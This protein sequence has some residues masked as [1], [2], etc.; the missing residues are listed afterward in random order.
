VDSF[1]P[2]VVSLRRWRR[3]IRKWLVSIDKPEN[4]K[5]H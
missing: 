3:K 5:Y 2:T 1:E 4:N